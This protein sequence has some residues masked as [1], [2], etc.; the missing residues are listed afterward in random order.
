MATSNEWLT[1]YQRSFNSIKTKIISTLRNKIPEMTDFSE[2]NIFIIIVSIFSAIA[3]V[4]HYYIDNMAREAFLP[5]ARRYSSV[6]NHAKLV[7]YHIKSANPAMVDLTLYRSDGAIV[8][9]N[10]DIEANTVFTSDDGK[11]WLTSNTTTWETGNNSVIVSVV[12]KELVGE[13]NRISLGQITSKDIKI[14]LP[15]LPTDKKYMEG[16]MVLYIDQEPWTLVDTFAYASPIDKVYKIELDQDLK[17]Y[18]IFGD[19]QFGMKPDLNGK[20]EGTYYLTYGNLGNLDSGSFTQV[21]QKYLDI[22]DD[23]QVTNIYPAAGGSDY[24]DFDTLKAHIPLSIK[25]LGVAITKEDFEAL[26]RL[27]PGVDKAYVNYN[28][29]KYVEIYITPDNG[30]IASQNLLNQVKAKLSRSKVITTSIEVYSVKQATIYI[31][32]NVYGKK[33]FSAQDI[34]EQV[35][36]ALLNAY[37]RRNSD[38]NKVVRLSDIYALIDNQTMVD[39]VNIDNLFLMGYPYP[40]NNEIAEGEEDVIPELS[41]SYFN[42]DIWNYTDDSKIVSIKIQ[43]GNTSASS[44]VYNVYLG[45][46]KMIATG[47]VSF[48]NSCTFKDKMSNPNLQITLNVNQNGYPENSYYIFTLQQPNRD[49]TPNQYEIPIFINSSITVIPHETV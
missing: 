17:P 45:D 37:N 47:P 8:D 30:I 28:C 48:N 13:P 18:I 34:T 10:I 33:S 14:Y 43:M 44:G 6:Y 19:G 5:T 39:Y 49:L 16:S 26:A 40:H 38:I 36:T 22:Y 15:D 32:C 1:P 29:G 9:S 21:P 11:Q 46:D 7:D 24:E 25:T 41:L 2:G 27:Q 42:M 3:E 23:I 20:V 35:K 31:I 4:I 12:Q